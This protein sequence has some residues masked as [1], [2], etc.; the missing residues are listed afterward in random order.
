MLSRLGKGATMPDS[1]VPTI[2]LG[3]PGVS[4]EPGDHLC[5]LYRGAERDQVLIPYLREGLRGSDKVVCVVDTNEPDRFLTQLAAEV[6]IG[7]QVSGQRF[8]V[9]HSRDTYLRDGYFAA[10]EM[11]DFWEQA[12][13]AA[14]AE[15]YAFARATGEMTWS[16]RDCPGV[17]ELVGYESEANRLLPRYPVVA[18]CMY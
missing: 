9:L 1:A 3:V 13:D 18:M 16:L 4:I 8:E 6:D 11:L 5:A 15:G 14:L 17:D 12:L 10:Q 2:P 7:Q